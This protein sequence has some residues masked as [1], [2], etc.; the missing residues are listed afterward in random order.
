VLWKHNERLRSNA[1]ELTRN[2][3]QQKL[4]LEEAAR[5][6]QVLTAGDAMHVTVLPVNY[7]TPPPEGRAIYS[8]ERAGLVFVASNL[9]SLPAQKAYELWLIPM[10]GAPIP[11][12][13]FK[14]D[15][16][17]G[18]MV[19]NPPLPAG[20]EAKAFAVTIEPEAGSQ[21]PTMPI[22]MMGAGS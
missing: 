18:A 5:V 13:M 3:E 1:V 17:G 11:A 21:T 14:P 20:V 6:A 2:S 10:H 15:A 8:R 12:G 9:H 16:R 7:K 4:K 22:V 19:L